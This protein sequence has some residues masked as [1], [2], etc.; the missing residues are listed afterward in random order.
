MLSLEL[1][2]DSHSNELFDF[3]S[4]IDINLSHQI[5]KVF[6]DP[7]TKYSAQTY[8]PNVIVYNFVYKNVHYP[9]NHYF[10]DSMLE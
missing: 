2:S 5:L 8:S 6:V 3:L 7:N 9:P 10:D 1:L 4:P